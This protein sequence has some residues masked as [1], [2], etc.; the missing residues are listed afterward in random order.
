MAAGVSDRGLR[1][2]RNE[3]ALVLR[4][5]GSLENATTRVLAV[6]CDGVSSSPRPDDAAVAAAQTG[7]DVMVAALRAGKT[8]EAATREAVGAAGD[9]VTALANGSE[10]GS[11]PACTYVSALVAGD[12]VTLGWVGDSRVYWLPGP[13]EALS[14]PAQLTE[15]DSWLAQVLASGT[16]TSAE[17][18]ADGRAH[19]ITGWLGADATTTGPH[20]S[21][22]RPGGPGVI[23]VCTD[24]LWNYLGHPHELA[25]TLP[26]N[27][28][29]APLDAARHL[30]DVA[31]E[32]GGH[33]NVTVAVLPFTTEKAG[34]NE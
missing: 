6:V 8:P 30:V 15:D 14:S 23:V 29:E 7:A 26:L 28:A 19:A 11:A 24:G 16:L 13:Q 18:A 22:F 17:A 1:H 21:V 2:G 25:A 27:A 4:R 3:D 5:L 33:D 31:L 34:G 20:V 12:C 10:T 32:S 9:A